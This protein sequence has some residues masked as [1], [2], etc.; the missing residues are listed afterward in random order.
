[1]ILLS[2]LDYF[3]PKTENEFGLKYS[4]LQPQELL[5]LHIEATAF[6]TLHELTARKLVGIIYDM[7]PEFRVKYPNWQDFL[8]G[9]E[10]G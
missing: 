8:G 4:N 5:A 2:S 9:Y 3:L 7:F 10:L 1:L 6:I